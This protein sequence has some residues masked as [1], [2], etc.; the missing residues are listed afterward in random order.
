MKLI[1]TALP[2]E[3]Q[4]LIKSFSLK[5]DLR[6]QKIPLYFGEDLYL[7]VSGVGKIKSA[8]ATT[9]ALSKIGEKESLIL[10]NFGICGTTDGKLSTGTFCWV[11]KIRDASTGRNYF[12]EALL[13]H[14]FPEY[15]LVTHDRPVKKEIARI[16][17]NSRED[18]AHLVDMEASGFFAAAQAFLPPERIICVKIVSDHLEG[19]LLEKKLLTQW[20][21]C[22]LPNMVQLFEQSNTLILSEKR[23]SPETK[24]QL[25][26]IEKK[27]RLTS[28]Q[29][30][31][32][33]KAAMVY[34]KRKCSHHRLDFL[35]PHCRSPKS[36]SERNACFKKIQE[37]LY[38]N[39]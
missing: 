12:P 1:I 3:A 23:L 21:E 27:L 31:Q 22:S 4:P 13:T 24:K 8:I 9:F 10:F 11:N 17:E 25:E 19:R 2:I 14:G 18:I 39:V 20:I 32:L 30:H 33:K 37:A 35:L 5:K 28:T 7:A 26:S 36:K 38:S 15:S 6:S 29:S 16:K 34:L